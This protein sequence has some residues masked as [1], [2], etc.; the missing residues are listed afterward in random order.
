MQD[1][2]PL[3]N[4]YDH[5]MSQARKESDREITRLSRSNRNCWDARDICVS[6]LG[7]IEHDGRACI[8]WKLWA[9]DVD[10]GFLNSGSVSFDLD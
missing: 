4:R 2:N 8:T 5:A 7:S 3:K 10:G 1:S 6:F 9:V